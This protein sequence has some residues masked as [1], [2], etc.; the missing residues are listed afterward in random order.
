[1]FK[2]RRIAVPFVLIALSVASFAAE[3]EKAPVTAEI[4][5][6]G[7]IM[8]AEIARCAQW[9]KDFSKT[10]LAQIASEPEVKQ[11][12]AGPFS[13]ISNLI[14][15]AV[16]PAPAPAE[17]VKPA[18]PSAVTNAF[19][20]LLD[21]LSQFTPGPF[22]VAVRFSP[23]DAQAGRP[24]AVAVLLGVSPG[25][26]D[27][28]VNFVSMLLESTLQK[29]PD[30]VISVTDYQNVKIISVK[31]KDAKGREIAAALTVHKNHLILT[32]DESLC[33]Q[34][35]DG[36]AGTLAK[37]LSE[38]ETY[39]N[40]G[41]SG[42]E[43]L[44]AYLDINGLKS[45]LGAMAKPLPDQ[46]NQLDDFFALSGLNKSVAVAW[47]LE[48]NGPAFE[49][50]T[51]VFTTG[52]R[53]G[54]LGM[55]DN[56]PISIESLKICPKGA[57]LAAGF[58][59]RSDRLITFFRSLARAIQGQKGMETLNN[60]ITKLDADLHRNL[61]KEV[62]EVFGNEI[63]LTSLAGTEGGGPIGAAS[64]VTVSVSV[65]DV[66]KAEEILSQVLG[67]IAKNDGR[68][69]EDVL[70]EVEYDGAKIRYLTGRKVAGVIDL[71]PSFVIYKNRLLSALDVPTL[72]R[73]MNVLKGA[74]SLANSD[75]FTAALKESGGRMGPAF[76]YVDWAYVYNTAYNVG[77]TALR[78]VA[79]ADLLKQIGIDM[80]L[81]P[82]A[83]TVSRH[84]FPAL[85]VAQTTP[86][87]VILVSRSP[88]PSVE[89]LAPPLA[90]V[91][92]V[93]ATFKPFLTVADK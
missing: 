93:F 23:E 62:P 42:H 67:Q 32:S 89:V 6:D 38:N 43:H 3:G 39:K 76:S 34:I 22:V 71:S 9:S 16:P 21:T 53:E 5:P 91:S 11:F 63:V 59:I 18:E 55:L 73:A 69:P 24:P 77:T 17:P 61:E 50:R 46:P 8:Y 82:P 75:P 85:S 58:R 72:K 88:L 28:K 37:K 78:M 66:A 79:P 2:L 80:N 31:R 65:Q 10:S 33:K 30:A 12:L 25:G 20:S 52:E 27:A 84:L 1:M 51:A 13:Q 68:P 36:M 15:K 35:I 60:A 81:L 56:Q 47:S 14:K 26:I 57:P 86:S 19:N 83:D 29:S 48:M 54:L 64:Q 4:L 40:T 74:D 90:A 41:L 44:I 7:T 87:G 45:A 92:A 70:K 49:S